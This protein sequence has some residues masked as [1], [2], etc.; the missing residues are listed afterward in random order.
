ML[1]KPEPSFNFPVVIITG[2][3]KGIGAAVA[4]RFGL[5]GWQ[6]VVAARSAE[7]LEQVVNEIRKAGGSALAVKAD[8]TRQEDINHLV[9][10]VIEKYGRIDV[11]VNNA[12][13]GVA[14]TI[15]TLNM[16][17]LEEG[18]RLN[19]LAPVA[20]LQAVV[21]Y[22]KNQKNGV[23]VNMSSM[24]ESM[25]VPYMGAYAATKIALG[26]LS[27]SARIELS[28]ENINV[29][30]VLPGETETEFYDNVVQA[31]YSKSFTEI[32]EKAN[33][34]KKTTPEAVAEAVW[35][36]VHTH[37]HEIFVTASDKLISTFTRIFPKLTNWIL[38]FAIKRYAPVSGDVAPGSIKNDARKIL[39]GIVVGLSGVLAGVLI[40]FSRK[41]KRD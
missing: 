16:N 17:E 7:Q 4:K 2:G 9:R 38:K 10:F 35:R 23:I 34:L 13:A 20:M 3:S 12:G 18:F 19:V 37:Q 24:V 26:Y 31:G 8:V 14:G 30:K 33:F 1:E 29:I 28:E 40:V 11:L 39:M 25:A 21:P 15:A 36:G 41:S 32:F 5:G 22:M 6:V 27:D